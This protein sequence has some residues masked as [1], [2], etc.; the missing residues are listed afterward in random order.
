MVDENGIQAISQVLVVSKLSG[1]LVLGLLDLVFD[2]CFELAPA[3]QRPKLGKRGR[4]VQVSL[5][6]LRKLINLGDYLRVKIDRVLCIIRLFSHSCQVFEYF[7]S[8]VEQT[9]R[10]HAVGIL[11]YELDVWA[12][13]KRCGRNLPLDAVTPHGAPQAL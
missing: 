8:A 6:Y 9:R 13:N 5:C 4:T 11:Y 3:Y 10:I 7:L 1:D 2:I 12:H